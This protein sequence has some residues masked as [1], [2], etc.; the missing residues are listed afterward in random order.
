MVIKT[1]GGSQMLGINNNNAL[2]SK[3]DVYKLNQYA[4]F[5]CT[6]KEIAKL[7]SRTEDSIYNK[8]SELKISLNPPDD[9]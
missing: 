8:A 7:L 2:W 3:Q 1:Y 6:T 5:G 9:N 4:E